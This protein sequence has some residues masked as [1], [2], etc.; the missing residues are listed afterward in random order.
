MQVYIQRT[1]MRH[2]YILQSNATNG[3]RTIVWVWCVELLSE[4]EQIEEP[5]LTT[6]RII[7]RSEVGTSNG[8][9]RF[10]EKVWAPLR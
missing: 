5:S 4:L 2:M 7:S 8:W 1:C 3:V 9:S 6:W 10:L